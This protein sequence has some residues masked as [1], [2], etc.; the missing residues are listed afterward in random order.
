MSIT[1]SKASLLCF[2]LASC[3]H[4]SPDAAVLAPVVAQ[5]TQEPVDQAKQPE[6]LVFGD[7]LTARVFKG[8]RRDPRY[9][10][11]P[12]GKP[13]VCPADGS[14]CPKPYQLSARVNSIVGDTAIA[15]IERAHADGG[16]RIIYAEHILLVRRN[17]RWTVE[18]VLARS[19]TVPM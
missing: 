15:T 7:E 6:Y 12:S 18:K 8:L 17:G 10:V 19:A 14:P 9:R 4:S 1:R 16:Q 5:F 13:F 3:F 2:T 11:V